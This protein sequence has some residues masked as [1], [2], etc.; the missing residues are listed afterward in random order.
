MRRILDALASSVGRK[1]VMGLTGLLLVG[2]LIEHLLGNFKLLEDSTGEAF[3]EYVLWLKS[4]GPLLQLAELGLAAL[5]LCHIALALRLTLENL[6]ARK[7]KYVVRGTHGEKTPGSVTMFITGALIT[8]YL[9]KHLLDFRFDER[10][11]EDPA[12]FVKLTLSQPQHGLAYLM[13]AFVVG[14]HLSH[15]FRSAF[16][17]LGLSH[18]ALNAYLQKLGIAIAVLFATGFAVFPLY[19][20]FA[21]NGPAR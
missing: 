4:F 19:F 15:G 2:F 5:F 13:A 7:Q 9:V 11:F 1:I 18:P 21:W 14:L 6:A 17:S 8:G 16:Q 20:L 3:N 10:Y 12:A